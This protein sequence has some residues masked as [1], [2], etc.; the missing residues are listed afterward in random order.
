MDGKPFLFANKKCFS[1]FS[2]KRNPRKIRWTQFYR[3]AHRKNK[4]ALLKK[5]KT[6]RIVKKE[7]GIV[8]ASLDLI[9]AR[10][11]QQ[12]E[13][14]TAT[15]REQA[16]KELKE[17]KRA[18]ALRRKKEREERRKK[19]KTTEKKDKKRTQREQNKKSKN[20]FNTKNKNIGLEHKNKHQKINSVENHYL[21][22][23]K[24]NIDPYRIAEKYNLTV[25]KKI[26]IGTSN[27]YWLFRKGSSLN[28]ESENILQHLEF[29]EENQ[30]PNF[31][32][33]EL[34]LLGYTPTDPLFPDQYHLKN[35]G[36]LYS[37]VGVDVNVNPVWDEG[38]QGEGKIIAIVDDGVLIT[39]G[40]I[41]PNYQS[42]YSYN[43]CEGNND[44]SPLD[45][46][47]SH[48]T[49]CAGVCCAANSDKICGVGSSPKAT[50][51]GRRILC[52][53]SST[54]DYSE[55]LGQNC[56]SIDIFSSSWGPVGCDSTGCDYYETL[57][58]LESTILECCEN[59][60]NGK[61][62]IYLFAAG[63]ERA[64]GGDIN[65]FGLNKHSHVIA[66]AAM[67]AKCSYTSY[68]NRGSA[69]LITA[70]SSGLNKE[71]VFVG[72]RSS[73]YGSNSECTVS[74]GGTSSATPAVAGVVALIL[75]A[76]SELSF[77]DVQGILV[78]SAR[79][80]NK[81]EKEW[82]INGAKYQYSHNYGYGLVNAEQAVKIAKTWDYLNKTKSYSSDETD[83][84][85]DIN[86]GDSEGTFFDFVLDQPSQNITIIG[87][88]TIYLSIN[89]P[90][91]GNLA[92]TLTSPSGM[93]ARLAESTEMSATTLRLYPFVA[94]CFYG[95]L[96]LGKWQL[97]I[98]DV[99][100]EESGTLL[101]Y[102]IAIYGVEPQNR[103]KISYDDDLPP[104][105]SIDNNDTDDRFDYERLII[106]VGAFFGFV[107]IIGIFSC[108]FKK[109]KKKIHVNN[110]QNPQNR[111]LLNEG[112]KGEN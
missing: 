74:F 66:V 27:R 46:D 31:Q 78:E 65:Q 110:L 33:K 15:L 22:K 47:D 24:A 29:I 16:I 90:L 18:K 17:R 101:S 11:Q 40:D 58:S 100:S 77:W 87:G 99:K 85:K 76:N 103:N 12:K 96:A 64:D 89:Y 28:L 13:M 52:S 111:P 48:G 9:N 54:S 34:S 72:I 106:Y 107:F 53:G 70:P 59:G 3:K 36:Q 2:H 86:G 112:G 82:Q 80:I 5:K 62:S 32:K 97:N 102:S 104:D 84:N 1:R 30:F 25:V 7:R 93:V 79:F 55:S 10:R 92:I 71:D 8:G 42:E 73:T 6:R 69:L 88:F 61:G 67:N 81:E 45:S 37:R 26:K 51:V 68:S 4:S 43:W 94:K 49:S 23:T 41:S 63:N 98:K 57:S 21:V 14:K 50:I 75:E 44:P 19:K 83:I 39:H 35:T 105:K 95:E 108:I 56:D 20:K 38:Y 60:R 91:I 109:K